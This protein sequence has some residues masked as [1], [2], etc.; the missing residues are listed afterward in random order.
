M[1]TARCYP[2]G[3]TKFVDPSDVSEAIKVKDQL[4][5]VDVSSPDA[6]DLALCR[7]SSR[8]RSRMSSMASAEAEPRYR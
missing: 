7:R 1:I 8:W 6:E 5:W 4:V 2:D 3:T